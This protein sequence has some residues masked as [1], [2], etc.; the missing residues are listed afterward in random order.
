MSVFFRSRIT[1]VGSYVPP[2]VW[3]NEDL[4]EIMDTSDEWIQQRTGIKQRHWVEGS[5]ATSDL[6]LEASK[7]AIEKAGIKKEDIDMIVLG[8][9][10]PDYEFPGTACF[11]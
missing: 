5:T 1:G 4:R 10:S 11:L 7:R 9:L 6:A 3:K 2:K 8:T